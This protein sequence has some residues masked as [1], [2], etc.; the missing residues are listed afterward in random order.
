MGEATIHW[1][2]DLPLKKINSLPPEVINYQ[3]LL[4]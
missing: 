1:I 3:Q 2:I 4:N